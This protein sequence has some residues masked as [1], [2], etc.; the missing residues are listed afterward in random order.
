MTVMTKFHDSEIRILSTLCLSVIQNSE[1]SDAYFDI[2]YGLCIA[3]F[4]ILVVVLL[5][6]SHC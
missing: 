6:L 1:W 4:L 2:V 3:A 5:L